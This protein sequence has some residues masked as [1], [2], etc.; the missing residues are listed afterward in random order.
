[1]LQTLLLYTRHQIIQQDS[2]LSSPSGIHSTTVNNITMSRRKVAF[3]SF[4]IRPNVSEWVH[5]DAV[6]SGKRNLIFHS[7]FSYV[8]R[9][10]DRVNLISNF[11]LFA[12]IIPL[13]VTPI[14][15]SSK[16]FI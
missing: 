10:Y 5:C 4:R 15:K 11:H 8:H 3:H 9:K 13:T 12:N 1:M 2:L 6:T 7:L 16:S 14:G